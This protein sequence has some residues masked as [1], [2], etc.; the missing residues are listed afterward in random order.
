MKSESVKSW[1][2]WDDDKDQWVT[3]FEGTRTYKNSGNEYTIV[4]AAYSA[5][6]AQ[7]DWELKYHVEVTGGV[8]GE[9]P[10]VCGTD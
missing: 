10:Q 1:E 7:G 4:A 6:N 3:Q 8:F 9:T 2:E 5:K